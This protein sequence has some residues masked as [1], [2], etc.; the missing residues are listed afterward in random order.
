MCKDPSRWPAERRLKND[1][2]EQLGQWECHMECSS[3]K[4][5][6]EQSW[7]HWRK[8]IQY[9]WLRGRDDTKMSRLAYYCRTV[10]Y[11][12]FYVSWC[13]VDYCEQEWDAGYLWTGARICSST[14]DSHE[15]VI[16]FQQQQYSLG[17]LHIFDYKPSPNS[18]NMEIFHCHVRLLH[19]AY[20]KI[21]ISSLRSYPSKPL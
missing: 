9:F 8:E 18:L 1:D 12:L 14:N 20:P 6:C 11:S 15:R 4:Q 3:Q 21:I 10:G 13:L 2:L 16:L 7:W 17:R 19:G 5:T